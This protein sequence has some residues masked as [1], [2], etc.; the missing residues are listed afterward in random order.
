MIQHKVERRRDKLRVV[1]ELDL[2]EVLAHQAPELRVGYARRLN[3]YLRRIEPDVF[4]VAAILQEEGEVGTVKWF[5]ESKGYGFIRT[6]D[7]QDIFVHHSGIVG[8]GFKKLEANQRV[9][10][11]RRVGQERSEAVDVELE[12]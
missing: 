6:Y 12:E 8:D 5:D 10:F 11:K 9:R 7:R 1:V 2:G 4:A 3:E